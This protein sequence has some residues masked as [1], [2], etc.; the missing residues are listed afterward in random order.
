MTEPRAPGEGESS[1]KNPSR[2][3]SVAPARQESAANV[4]ARRPI[5]RAS[6]DRVLARA[7]E[8]QMSAGMPAEGA[9]TED[10]L[11]ELGREVGLSSEY[12]R[13][14]LSEER[15]RVAPPSESG[16]MAAMFG[17]SQASAMRV[18]PGTPEQVMASLDRWMQREECLQVKRRFTD[19][20]VWEARR[21]IVGSIRRGFNIGGR[22]Y[23]LSRA[24]DV[25]AT[26][27]PAEAGRSMVRLDA[28]L[29]DARGQR[30]AGSAGTL[31]SGVVV[32]GVFAII[33]VMLPV[34]LLPAVIALPGAWAVG[35]GHLRTL[36]RAQLALEQVLDKLE[37]GEPEQRGQGLL[38]MLSPPPRKQP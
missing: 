38:S 22:G 28:H 35:R 33:G 34:A 15:T 18:V 23:H 17:A 7:A 14:A 30:V 21:D 13:Q 6:L 26:V 11:L 12:L 9:L 31:A 10:Q 3:S 36:T 29:G 16:V 25:A 32:S 5:D 27:L 20:V 1:G 24:D 8:L 37:Y 19:R 2:D 4:P